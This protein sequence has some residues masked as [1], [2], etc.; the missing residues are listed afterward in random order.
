M[1]KLSLSVAGK[2]SC[3]DEAMCLQ[4]FFGVVCPPFPLPR[5]LIM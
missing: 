2:Q 3:V 5:K 4:G 1:S